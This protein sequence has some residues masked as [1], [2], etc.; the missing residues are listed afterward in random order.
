MFISSIFFL[1][2]KRKL[3]TYDIINIWC[4]TEKSNKQ[5]KQIKMK[6]S[7]TALVSYDKGI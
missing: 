1:S 2:I 5:I 6:H 7:G 3:A 4:S